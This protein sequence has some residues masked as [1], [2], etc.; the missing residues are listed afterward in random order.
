MV[1]R[2]R[3]QVVAE[4]QGPNVVTSIAN[5]VMISRAEHLMNKL[6]IIEEEGLLNAEQAQ[7]TIGAIRRQNLC[8][9]VS[10]V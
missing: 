4:L 9:R 7:E 3:C 1:E 2:Q 6:L 5:M 10:M 8:C